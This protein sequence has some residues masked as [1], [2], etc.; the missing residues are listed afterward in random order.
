[1]TLENDQANWTCD[2]YELAATARMLMLTDYLAEPNDIHDFLCKPSKWEL[3]R[4]IWIEAGRPAPNSPQWDL[5]QEQ[6]E[7]HENPTLNAPAPSGDPE[8]EPAATPASGPRMR[9]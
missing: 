1:M 8:S 5:L 7:R 2:R 9:H 4:N 6:L 3:V